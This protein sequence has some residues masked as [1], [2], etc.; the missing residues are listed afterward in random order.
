M[1]LDSRSR[2]ADSS[3][4]LH[5]GNFRL[6]PGSPPGAEGTVLI[7]SGEGGSPRPR[8]ACTLRYGLIGA[9]PLG[10]P[11]EAGRRA[12]LLFARC[13]WMSTLASVC[14]F[15]CVRVSVCL[16]LS[17]CTCAMTPLAA[18]SAGGGGP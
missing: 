5:A 18:L 7:G 17:V 15:L 6:N 16:C 8:C 12:M 11:E 9:G 14:V 13:A 3:C 10:I 2:E 4:G 1:L